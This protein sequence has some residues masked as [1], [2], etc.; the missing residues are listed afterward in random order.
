MMQ[1]EGIRNFRDFGG[2]AA[3]RE[4]LKRGRFRR[5]LLLRRLLT[6]RHVDLFRRYFRALAEDQGAGPIHCAGERTAQACWPR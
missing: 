6:P 3:G 4:R 5:A 2:Y 1:L